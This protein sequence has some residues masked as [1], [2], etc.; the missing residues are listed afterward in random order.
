MSE[1]GRA[2]GRRVTCLDRE[3]IGER[4][5]KKEIEGNERDREKEDMHRGREKWGIGER[6]ETY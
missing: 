2:R 5:S 1:R 6:R 4:D 3:K